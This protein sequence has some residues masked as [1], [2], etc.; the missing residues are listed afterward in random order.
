MDEDLC[1][2]VV[3]SAVLHDREAFFALFFFVQ[4]AEEFVFPFEDLGVDIIFLA[5]FL[6]GKAFDVLAKLAHI[7]LSEGLAGAG[8]VPPDGGFEV[9]FADHVVAHPQHNRFVLLC[10]IV[11]LV[12]SARLMGRRGTSSRTSLP[13]TWG[14]GGFF[15]ARMGLG[16]Q[17]SGGWFGLRSWD[18]RQR[19]LFDVRKHVLRIVLGGKAG[20]KVITADSA[21]K[22]QQH[23]EDPPPAALALDNGFAGFVKVLFGVVGQDRSGA[24]P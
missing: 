17:R 2:N 9:F 20:V 21:C 7:F 23:Q 16:T 11:E 18:M 3:T 1:K 22:E 8:V 4:V 24:N 13:R 6:I 12:L 14:G 10:E 15:D 5:D 19:S